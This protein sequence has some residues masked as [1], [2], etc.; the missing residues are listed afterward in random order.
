MSDPPDD[1]TPS[2]TAVSVGPSGS[3]LATRPSVWLTVTVGGAGYATGFL[4]AI[5]TYLSSSFQYGP[6]PS[7]GQAVAGA[8]VPSQ[9][10]L[11]LI[12]EG[13]SSAVAQNRAVVIHNSRRFQRCLAGLFV[14]VTYTVALVTLVWLDETPVVEWTILTA[15]T[16]VAGTG[17]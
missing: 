3:A 11:D 8:T 1:F 4:F 17:L 16:V 6:P 5:V 2:L 14:G 13:Y 7:L 15:V 12:L 10:Y 9:E